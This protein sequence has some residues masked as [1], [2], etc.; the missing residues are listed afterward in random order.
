MFIRKITYQLKPECDTEKG[1][2]DMRNALARAFEDTE[3]MR[4]VSPIMP[5]V[6]GKYEVI[7][8]YYDEAS[9]RAATPK[10]QEEWSRFSHMLVEV[11]QIALYGTT[12]KELL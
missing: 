5:K 4:S 3:G 10:V 12:L 8:V 2:R 9:A 6:E 11:P 1:H 7:T